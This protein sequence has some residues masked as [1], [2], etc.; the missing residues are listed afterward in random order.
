MRESVSEYYGKTLTKSDDLRTS[1]CCTAKPPPPEVVAVLRKVPEEIRSRW[2]LLDVLV[3]HMPTCSG[4]LGLLQPRNISGSSS[5]GHHN[6]SALV[7][8]TCCI[9]ATAWSRRVTTQCQ[10][11]TCMLHGAFGKAATPLFLPCMAMPSLAA[12]SQPSV[13]HQPKYSVRRTPSGGAAHACCMG[14]VGVL[15]LPDSWA[16]MAMS[17][18]LAASH[19][20][21]C[22]R[23]TSA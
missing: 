14:P 6:H 7:H 20:R 5:S 3:T 9:H 23:G 2:G 13:A 21:Q 17:T 15:L 16:C 10:N 11:Y 4:C 8:C 18:S 12:S 22:L 19:Q 1:A